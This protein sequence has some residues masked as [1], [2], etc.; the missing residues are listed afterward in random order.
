M[1]SRLFLSIILTII[2]ST[3]C[4]KSFLE[5]GET[6]ILIRDEYVRDLT[7]TQEVLNGVY[8]SMATNLFA[9]Y[10]AIYPDLIADNI[11]PVS[12]PASALDAHYNWAQ[13]VGDS[14]G[15]NI[16]A[17]DLNANGFSYASYNMIRT[18]SF[19]IEKG[20]EFRNENTQK[21]D[22]IIGQAYAIR[23]LV[24]HFLVNVFAQ[25]PN[26]TPGATHPG[27][28]YVTSSDYTKP[29]S[30]QT[31][32]EVYDN[33]I[34]DLTKAI[35]LLPENFISKTAISRNAAKALLARVYLFKE[36]FTAAKNIAYEISF[37]VPVLTA[38]YPG[39]LF[40]TQ[41]AEALFHITPER[42]Y[43]LFAGAFFTPTYAEYFV[44]TSD[45]ANLL[46]ANSNDKRNI[47]VENVS[48]RWRIK[49]FPS[50]VVSGI[51]PAAA[52]YYQ[53]VIRSSEMYLTAAES[54]ARI[55]GF[56][57]S[58]RYFLNAIRL[59]ADPSASPVTS[60]G[61]DLL[62]SIYVERRK[63]L[64]FESMRMFDLLRW[65]KGVTR[66]DALS[67]NSQTLSFPNNKAIAP[68]P[69]LDARMAGIPQNIGY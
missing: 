46:T 45:I 51:S 50:G 64:C 27:I 68:I 8:I 23:A 33:L 31:V 20:I 47:W 29:V 52:S 42:N 1:N 17:G 37:K 57:D 10:H 66:A 11:R 26:F 60:G 9:N 30:R 13:I 14:K 18:C 32:G 36:N 59:R 19:I 55:G 41:D 61:T 44:A 38:N 48:G 69:G 12:L 40:T 39:N 34:A 56:E 2:L 25:S 67:P 16:Q 24:H 15:N 49:K 28:A 54:Y 21:A 62:D 22:I 65:K 53:P 35:E 58:A 5:I 43:A 6:Q 7:T 3:G 63:E 4:K